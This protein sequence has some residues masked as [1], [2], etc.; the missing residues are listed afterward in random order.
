MYLDP[1]GSSTVFPPSDPTIESSHYS[2]CPIWS[3]NSH[4]Y[5]ISLLWDD[6]ELCSPP[7]DWFSF[8][9]YDSYVLFSY[10]LHSSDSVGIES[11]SS[12]MLFNH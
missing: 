7:I 1:I 11:D 4:N 8:S 6:S 3:H 12:Q 2:Q 10:P 5:D 9:S